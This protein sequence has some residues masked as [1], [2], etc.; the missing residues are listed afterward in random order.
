MREHGRDPS[1]EKSSEILNGRVTVTTALCVCDD[2]KCYWIRVDGKWERR[3]HG[4]SGPQP[5]S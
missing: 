3:I 4:K 2:S 1:T 5:D